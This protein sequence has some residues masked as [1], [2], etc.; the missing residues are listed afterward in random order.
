MIY[1]IILRTTTTVR[2]A[3]AGIGTT[4]MDVD[5][6]LNTV[7]S[8]TIVIT[9]ARSVK[10]NTGTTIGDA[11]KPSNAVILTITQITNVNDVEA[12]IGIMLGAAG[13]ILITVKRMNTGITMAA[14]TAMMTIGTKMTLADAILIPARNTT[15]AH[16]HVLTA[17]MSTGCTG[18][19][20]TQI[21][22]IARNMTLLTITTVKN[23]QADITVIT[24]HATE[25]F[26]TVKNTIMQIIIV[27]SAIVPTGITTPRAD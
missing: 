12:D 6:P 5:I 4:T 1:T 26:P 11:E 22:T 14:H 20:V 21:S 16:T 10:M 18:M 9:T 7:K 17:T 15:T 19:G 8:M 3:R 27:K 23:A 13:E 25:R 24:K 2:P